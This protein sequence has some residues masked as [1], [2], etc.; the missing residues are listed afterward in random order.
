M[1]EMKGNGKKT[2]TQE[3]TVVFLHGLGG[4]QADWSDVISLLPKGADAVAIDLPGGALGPKPHA[5]Y[6]P[7][8]MARFVRETIGR[9]RP[10]P[11]RLVGH[12][13]GGRVAGELA[14]IEP[15]FVAALVLVAPLGAVPFGLTERLKWKAMS[16][17]SIL[18]S[19]GEGSIRS[20]TSYGFASESSGKRAFVERTMA[21]RTGPDAGAFTRAFEK[22]VDGVLA[23]PPLTARLD[24]TRMPLL[25][26]SGALDPLSPSRDLLALRKTRPDARFVELDGLGHYPMIEDPARVAGT[27]TEFFRGL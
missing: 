4:S 10:G 6:E 14:A 18:E 22:V 7:D 16:R 25:V 24:G 8:E 19:V 20:A 15:S 23:A 17:R 2:K 9:E 1:S 13:I 3:P 27:L 26:V 12:S 11:V 21:A 5:G